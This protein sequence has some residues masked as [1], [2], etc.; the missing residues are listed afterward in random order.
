MLFSIYHF[1][2]LKNWALTKLGN[3]GIEMGSFVIGSM[4]T[5]FKLVVRR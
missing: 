2:S 1:I 5:P 3:N 4:G